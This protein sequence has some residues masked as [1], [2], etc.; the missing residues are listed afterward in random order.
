MDMTKAEQSHQTREELLDSA[1]ELFAKSGYDATSVAAICA[2]AGVS[3][4]AV[5]HHFESKQD[6]FFELIQRWLET[7]E[8]RLKLLENQSEQVPE[9]LISMAHVV[10]EVLEVG[11]PQLSIYLEF[12]N[13]ALRDQQ[14]HSTLSKPFDDFL[15]FFSEMLQSG[16]ERG[17]IR[18]TDPEMAARVITALAIGLI[19]QGLLNPDAADWNEVTE[20]GLNLLLKGLSR[21]DFG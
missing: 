2:A 15:H 11:G 6:L 13:Q 21:E 18:K 7:L 10:G 20:F 8:S 16:V 9:Q 14:V 3:K 17:V 4:G 12:W 5:Y 1:E 19:F